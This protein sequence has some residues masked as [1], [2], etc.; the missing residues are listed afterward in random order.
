MAGTK[1]DVL[2]G[3]NADFSQVNAP[4]GSS[5]ESNGLVTDGQLWI[6]STS[7]NAGGTHINVGNLTSPDSSIT[8][9]YSSPNITAQVSSG[10]TVG[11]TITGDTGGALSP[12]AG[13]W[14]IVGSGSITTSGSGSTLTT[15]LTGLTNHAVLVGAGTTTITKIGPSSTTGQIFQNNAGADPSYSTATYPSVATGTGTILRADGTNWVPTTATY[16]NTAGTS[17]NVLTSNGT[18]WVSSTAPGG[19]MLSATVVLTSAQ[20]KAL[21]VTPVT[22]VAAPGSGKVIWIM[23]TIT[24]M[25]YGG[26]NQFT[27]GGN[28]Q[29]RYNNG[30][31]LIAQGQIGTTTQINA[32][33][34]TY[35]RQVPTDIAENLTTALENLPIVAFNSGSAYAGNAA[36]NNTF[37]ITVQYFIS[38]I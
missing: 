12:N 35:L 4:N 6:G 19:G 36:N 3:K 37:T 20:V 27:T 13:N 15:Q 9:G 23:S 17:G 1:N 38:S 7:T 18:N 31:G 16:P 34:S 28:V 30:T 26:T 25:T 5:S 21:N 2:I 32:A 8:F 14:N 11:K 24:K 33:N 10:T 29:L 22:I